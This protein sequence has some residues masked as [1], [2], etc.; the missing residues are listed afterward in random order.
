M[1]EKI[2]TQSFL[3]FL[4][5]FWKINFEKRPKLTVYIFIR[6]HLMKKHSMKRF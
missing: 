1:N 4:L 5:Y 2:P 3:Y 6:R